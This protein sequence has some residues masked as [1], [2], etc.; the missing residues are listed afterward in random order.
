MLSQLVSDQPVGSA[1]WNV[2]GFF[3]LMLVG[4]TV[5]LVAW[6]AVDVVSTAW[7]QSTRR[8]RRV[9]RQAYAVKPV[10]RAGGHLLFI[11]VTAATDDGYSQVLPGLIQAG[12]A[13]RVRHG[14]DVYRACNRHA[15]K[16]LAAHH[17]R[18]QQELDAELKAVRRADPSV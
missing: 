9:W 5:Y 14:L 10:I 1:E 16:L 2:T 12:E 18:R 6:M 3:I 17:A 15:L 4:F 8:A 13:I 7:C 11:A